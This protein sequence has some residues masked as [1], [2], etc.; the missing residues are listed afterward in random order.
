MII[1]KLTNQSEHANF[2]RSMCLL[3][4][5]QKKKLRNHVHVLIKLLDFEIGLKHQ[6]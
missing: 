4:R 5:L 3:K 2:F 1:D 6:G